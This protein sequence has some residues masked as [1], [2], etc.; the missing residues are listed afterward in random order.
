MTT[1]SR[2]TFGETKN[3]NLKIT[4]L[5]NYEKSGLLESRGNAWPDRGI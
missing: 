5:W 4:D 1:S 2:N 3:V